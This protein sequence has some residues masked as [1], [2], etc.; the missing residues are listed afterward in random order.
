MKRK[1][2]PWSIHW[3]RKSLGLS[4]ASVAAL[5]VFALGLALIPYLLFQHQQIHS[6]YLVAQSS[7]DSVLWN[8]YQFER[9]HG[10]LRIALHSVVDARTPEAEQDLILQFE[11]FLSRLELIKNSPTLEELSSAPAYQTAIAAL[12]EFAKAADPVIS[13]LQ[14]RP[15]DAKAMQ[16]LLVQAN[17]NEEALRNLTNFAT[18]TV[19]KEMDERNAT[20]ENRGWWIF[21]LVALEWLILSIALVGLMVYIRKQ[22]QHQLES[23]R[24]TR[25]LRSASRKAESANQA[26]SVFL[27][28]MSHELRTP[29]QGL[30]G[31]LNL[32]SSTEL[33]DT[34][35]HYADTAARSTRHLLTVLNDILDI[36][37][38]ESGAMKL[39]LA[40]L[41]LRD[42]VAEVEA[43]MRPAASE[44]DIAFTV[45]VADALPH[46]IEVDATRLIQILFNLTSN[47]I[48]FTSVGTVAL[49][50]ALRPPPP[51]GAAAGLR[52]SV[53]DTGIGMDAQTVSSLF[54]RF[55]Q[56]DQSVHR[57]FGG[58]GLGL[59]ISLN[60]A[61]LMGGDI[62]TQS[63]LGEGSVF[64]LELPL[65]AVAPPA[66]AQ[67]TATPAQPRQRVLVVDD[68][69]V[70]A[71]YLSILLEQMGHHTHRCENGAQVLEHLKT[72][73]VDL[74][75]MDFHMPVLDGI[76]TTRAIRQLHGA[77]ASV[78]IVMVSADFSPDTRQAA[79]QAGVN[80]FLAK[81]VQAE[82]LSKALAPAGCAPAAPSPTPL[83]PPPLA[84]E[85][86]GLIDTSIY[87]EFVEL[88]PVETVKRYLASLFDVE[89]G[90]IKA[91]TTSLAA[92]Q[93]VLASSAAHQLR[94]VCLLMGLTGIARTLTQIEAA[95]ASLPAQAP[96][97]LLA[98]LLKDLQATRLALD[99]LT[100]V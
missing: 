83:A 21:A 32:L 36:S 14:A 55:Y 20:I 40:P 100:P 74:I 78:K 70:N 90:E 24:L 93:S 46:W 9:E 73:A 98:Q 57:R 99:S 44:K 72:E 67:A 75:L 47:A 76:S 27:A 89:H 54:S 66:P 80:D 43:L 11:I 87:Q 41:H 61:R 31:M 2:R 23:L 10:K 62:R 84:V 12:E 19:H 91:L 33:S 71:E 52:V 82:C 7:L 45:Q 5:V 13:N 50:L 29:F 49:E 92:G 81:P 58:T 51:E 97:G 56:A 25:R 94:G 96:K 37:A 69:P 30:L 34:Q 53:R 65:H 85:A 77:A 3:L 39:R 17:D 1:S 48:K 42:F 95:H 38:I 60:L 18:N 35:K 22:Q 63:R 8:T 28:N 59:E 26:K 4:P 6:K 79:L 86:T 16:G 68:H 64:T 15:W 88:M